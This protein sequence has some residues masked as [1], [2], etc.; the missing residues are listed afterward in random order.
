MTFDLRHP[1]DLF[2]Q[3]LELVGIDLKRP[4]VIEH[5]L[6]FPMKDAAELVAQGLRAEGYATEVM[7]CATNSNW[8]VLARRQMVPATERISRV[9]DQMDELAASFGGHYDGWGAPFIK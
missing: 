7:H 5:F 3:Q 4:Q 2:M 8:L 6:H 9:R 1:D